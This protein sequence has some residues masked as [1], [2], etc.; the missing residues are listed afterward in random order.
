MTAHPIIAGRLYWAKCDL[1]EGP[2]IA[3]NAADAICR[4]IDMVLPA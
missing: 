1:Y 2:V 4:L 3:A